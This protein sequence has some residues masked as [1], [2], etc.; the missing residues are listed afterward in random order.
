MS[1]LFLPQQTNLIKLSPFLG[2]GHFSVVCSWGTVQ[3]S[4]GKWKDGKE[5]EDHEDKPSSL[6]PLCNLVNLTRPQMISYKMGR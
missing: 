2:R 4:E 6:Q 5:T 1:L 3:R